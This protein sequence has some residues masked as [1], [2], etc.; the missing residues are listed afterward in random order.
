MLKDTDFYHLIRKY[1]KQLLD[2]ALNS[3]KTVSKKVFHKTGEF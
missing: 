1:N 2:T 3:L